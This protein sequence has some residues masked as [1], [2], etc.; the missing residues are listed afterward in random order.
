MLVQTPF[1]CKAELMH[2]IMLAYRIVARTFLRA[3]CC[4]SSMQCCIAAK[5]RR[6][7]CIGN[8]PGSKYHLIHS[9]VVHSTPRGCTDMFGDLQEW[10][11]GRTRLHNSATALLNQTYLHIHQVQTQ[12]K[13]NTSIIRTI[14]CIHVKSSSHMVYSI[15]HTRVISKMYV[16]QT[17]NC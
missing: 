13:F 14:F 2:F 17:G 4:G 10:L 6:P 9:Y 3:S 12:R 7:A 1:R 8:Y 16:Q 15:S 5:E 11:C